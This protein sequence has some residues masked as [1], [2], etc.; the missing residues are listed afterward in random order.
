MPEWIQVMTYGVPL[1]YFL[2]IVRGIYL[3]GVGM[4]IL[5]PQALALLGMGLFFIITAVF[6][7][8]KRL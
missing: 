6:R 4:E 5:W 2:E 8:K 1:R 3:R 7:F